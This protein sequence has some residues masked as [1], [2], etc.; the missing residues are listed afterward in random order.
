MFRMV[1]QI[2]LLLLSFKSVSYSWKHVCCS[3][4][5]LNSASL[6][7][8]IR[9]VPYY[10][11]PDRRMFSSMMNSK[12]CPSWMTRNILTK[13]PQ[14]IHLTLPRGMPFAYFCGLCHRPSRVATNITMIHTTAE[15]Q[16]IAQVT[17]VFCRHKL[18]IIPRCIPLPK[19]TMYCY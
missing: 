13:Q 16:P 6:Y 2:I 3:A 12:S 5:T 4:T 7:P 19:T 15:T 8:F 10:L 18:L 14:H 17:N 9:W 11:R 1:P